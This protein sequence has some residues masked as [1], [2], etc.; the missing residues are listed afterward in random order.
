MKNKLFYVFFILIIFLV[1][2][3]NQSENKLSFSE[4]NT[5]K[6]S[7]LEKE[8][9]ITWSKELDANRLKESISA[10]KL[11]DDVI[12]SIDI[13]KILPDFQKDIYPEFEN[14]G[15]LDSS[16]LTVILKEKITNICTEIAEGK[17]DKIKSSFNSNYIF[18]F[19]FFIN[20]LKKEWEKNF[21]IDFPENEVLF[22][23]WII[24]EPFFGEK[25]L[26]VPVR[27]YCNNG[28]V[29]VTLYMNIEN[30]YSIYQITINRWEKYDGKK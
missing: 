16:S 11:S 17:E 14:F 9:D 21:G 5:I 15:K 3:K 22:N 20:D 12:N 7:V 2:C 30:A 19:V 1:S 27:F 28:T 26:Q 23:K 29:D 25:I 6:K 8:N 13:M 24:G 18:N 4:E 10:K